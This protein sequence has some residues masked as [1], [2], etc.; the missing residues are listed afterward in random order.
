[1]GNWRSDIEDIAN[2]S[3]IVYLLYSGGGLTFGELLEQA[4][5]SKPTVSHHLKG[6][7]QQGRVLQ[8]GIGKDRK[9]VVEP[10]LASAIKATGI[11]GYLGA[12]FAIIVGKLPRKKKAR[13]AVQKFVKRMAEKEELIYTK[14]MAA[15][16]RA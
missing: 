4:Q 9:Y 11:D 2:S 14:R 5:L 7:M 3:T 13:A 8:E 10:A 6:L 15:R 1:M 16:S 12:L